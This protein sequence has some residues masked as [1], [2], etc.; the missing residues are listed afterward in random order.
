MASYA[1]D[2]TT[3]RVGA[4]LTASRTAA[5]NAASMLHSSKEVNEISVAIEMIDTG[6]PV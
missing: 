3:K 6:R 5:G 2:R 1:I 4:H